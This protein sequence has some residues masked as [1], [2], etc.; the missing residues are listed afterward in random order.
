MLINDNVTL[1]LPAQMV[2]CNIHGMMYSMLYLKRVHVT[3][4]AQDQLDYYYDNDFYLAQEMSGVLHLLDKGPISWCHIQQTKKG[5][6][7]WVRVDLPGADQPS[8]GIV[9]REMND[10]TAKVTYIGP[11]PG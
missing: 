6:A 11:F 8:Y 5:F 10:G 3:D 2:H 9:W 7:H 1:A 4:S